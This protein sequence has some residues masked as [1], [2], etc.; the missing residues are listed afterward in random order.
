[1]NP[2]KE[3][4]CELTDKYRSPIPSNKE[5]LIKNL[6]EIKGQTLCGQLKLIDD[7][8]LEFKNS[9]IN[10]KVSDIRSNHQLATVACSGAALIAQGGGL[11]GIAGHAIAGAVR[12]ARIP[13]TGPTA[14]ALRSDVM[15]LMAKG[16]IHSALFSQGLGLVG[17]RLSLYFNRMA[18]ACE[19]G[20]EWGFVRIHRLK[21]KIKAIENIMAQTYCHSAQLKAAKKGFEN[22]ISRCLRIFN[23][24][25]N[26]VSIHRGMRFYHPDGSSN[27]FQ[28][29]QTFVQKIVKKTVVDPYK[30]GINYIQK[31]EIE[32]VEDK[33]IVIYDKD[34]APADDEEI[35]EYLRDLGHKFR[36]KEYD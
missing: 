28:S 14:L 12:I 31:D 33:P 30:P 10:K 8:E 3:F 23:N 11:I 16:I 32:H 18:N 6:R 26:R 2:I 25:T 34:S 7:E 17:H 9:P 4:A 19:V 36:E 15:D 24:S 29:F 5:M 22:I 20:T 13:G 21:D 35:Y 1:M 27:S